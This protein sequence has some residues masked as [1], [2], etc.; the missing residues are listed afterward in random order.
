M[1]PGVDHCGLLPG[2][3]AKS[4]EFDPLPALEV[5]TQPRIPVADV[6]DLRR[7]EWQRVCWAAD[8]VQQ[9]AARARAGRHPSGPFVTQNTTDHPGRSLDRPLGTVTTAPG[10]W[11]LVRPGHRGDEY[12]LF[13][14]AE[15]RAA[16]GFRP[17][18][19]LPA[20]QRRETPR[21]PIP[22]MCAGA[23]CTTM[24]NRARPGIN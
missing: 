5:P 14:R 23:L 12:R 3:G 16:C 19:W 17:N 10:H 13:E 9:R 7:G 22:R 4:L 21:L 18:Y 1:L 24:A 15:L 20:T 8:G 2:P 11:G 6:V